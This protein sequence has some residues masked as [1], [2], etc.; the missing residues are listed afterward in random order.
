MFDQLWHFTQFNFWRGL[1]CLIAGMVVVA[2]CMLVPSWRRKIA[3]SDVDLEIVGLTALIVV[4]VAVAL[5]N[6]LGTGSG[7]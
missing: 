6:N 5:Y 4:I 2:P 7:A 1:I 3:R